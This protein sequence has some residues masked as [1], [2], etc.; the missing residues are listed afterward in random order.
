MSELKLAYPGYVCVPY[1]HNHESIALKDAWMKSKNITDLYFATA[2]FSSEGKLYFSDSTNHYIIAKFK[3]SSRISSEIKQQNLDKTSFLIT[4]SEELFQKEADG[5]MN[6]IT[7]YYLEYNDSGDDYNDIANIVGKKDKVSVA[8]LGRLEIISKYAP[9]F[10]FPYSDSM[11]CLE[12]S[13]EKSHQS[14]K[15]YCEKTRRDVSRRGLTM[16]NLMGLSLLEKLK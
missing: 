11:V 13:S 14:V 2:T 16:T 8:G 3:D 6:F 9:K 12:V 10:T 5:E 7:F 15:K 1:L 4:I